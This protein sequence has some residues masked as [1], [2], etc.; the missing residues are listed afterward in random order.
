LVQKTGLSAGE[1]AEVGRLEGPVLA[2]ADRFGEDDP[3]A[4]RVRVRCS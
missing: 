2:A 3:V 4:A 1:V